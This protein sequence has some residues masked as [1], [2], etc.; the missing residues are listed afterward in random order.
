MASG[1]GYYRGLGDFE[2]PINVKQ[3]ATFIDGENYGIHRFLSEWVNVH[4]AGDEYKKY[5]SKLADK[6]EK[7]LNEG[8]F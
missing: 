1:L 6:I 2:F 4:K 8:Y 5:G 7:L 3:L